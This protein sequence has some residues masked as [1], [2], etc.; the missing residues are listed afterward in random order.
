MD[1]TDAPVLVES[2]VPAAVAVDAHLD[3]DV[4]VE[5]A[6]RGVGAAISGCPYVLADAVHLRGEGVKVHVFGLDVGAENLA[7]RRD[8]GC[9]RPGAR[10]LHRVDVLDGFLTGTGLSL[11]LPPPAR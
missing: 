9:V 7:H 11:G 3:V 8:G 1:M 6:A 5:A 2:E 10:R 4:A